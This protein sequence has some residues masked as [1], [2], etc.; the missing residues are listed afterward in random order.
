MWRRRRNIDDNEENKWIMWKIWWRMKM[1]IMK[2][3]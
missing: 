1:K 3:W 2:V